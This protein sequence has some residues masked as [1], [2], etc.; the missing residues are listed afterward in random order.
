MAVGKVGSFAT[1]Q[2]AIV[3]FGG[4][5][6]GAFDKMRADEER[7]RREKEARDEKKR[8][9]I[10]RLGGLGFLKSTNIKGFNQGLEE[11][12]KPMVQEY[13]LAKEAG[14][15]TKMRELQ[16][17][18]FSMNDIVDKVV[19]QHDFYLKNKDDFDADYFNRA[20]SV[21]DNIDIANMDVKRGE[22]GRVRFTVY[23][24]PERKEVLF[25]DMTPNEIVD[26][27]KI[28]YKFDSEAMVKG[29]VKNYALDD[30]ERMINSGGIIGT[31][32]D[33]KLENNPRV[34]SAIESKANE[35]VNDSNA[36]AWFGSKVLGKY[37]ADAMGYSTEEKKQAK[38]EFTK[39]LKEAYK[40][41]YDLAIQQKRTGRGSGDK[42]INLGSVTTIPMTFV[43][44]DD[45]TKTTSKRDVLS[46]SI[47][48]GDGSRT[49]GISYGNTVLGSIM[50]DPKSNS[51]YFG[52]V[53]SGS[54]GI[55][56]G[57]KGAGNQNINTK[58]NVSVGVPENI[59]Y[60]NLPAYIQSDIQD[61]VGA[62]NKQELIE[63]IFGNLRGGNQA[64]TQ[65][66]TNT[67]SIKKN[68]DSYN[69]Q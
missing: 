29:F 28:P 18:I 46:V 44:G 47:G 55:S 12:Y 33:I 19:K 57:G 59:K 14:D 2:P 24:D 43:E 20:K 15:T 48:F 5:A 7:K 56:V 58:D 32:K 34:L 13:R 23:G 25:R 30:V 9:E 36:M 39:K 64:T 21:L 68:M 16:E 67:S 10:E 42:K 3:D 66:T 52:T 17:N 65:G 11:A 37:E 26:S 51:L 54:E 31:A 63:K 35:L 69:Q 41:E 60:E 40:S 8:Q 4:M 38:E 50:Y 45:K 53:T 6:Q 49:R 61:A 22:D 1:V 62:R 27:L